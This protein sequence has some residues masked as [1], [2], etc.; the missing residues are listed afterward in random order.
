MKAPWRSRT[1]KRSLILLALLTLVLTYSGCRTDEVEVPP[2]TGPSGHRLFLT[3]EANPDHLVIHAPGRPRERSEIEI[4]L[5]NQ[6]G[7]GVAGEGIKLRITNVNGAELNIGSLSDYNVTTDSNGY[8][9]VIY[10]APDSREQ[11][12][13][14]RV[15]IFAILTNASYVFEVVG[16]HAL[17]L[18]TSSV[19]PGPG[20]CVVSGGS[21]VAEFEFSPDPGTVGQPVCFDAQATEDPQGDEIVDFDFDFDDGTTGQGPATCH[22]FD[23]PGLYNV[24][25]VATDEHHNCD[26]VSHLVEVTQGD[27][28]TCSILVSPSAPQIDERVQFTILIQDPDD[29]SNTVRR[30]QWNFGDGSSTTTSRTTVDH[31]YREAGSYTVVATITDDTGNVSTCSTGVTVSE[32]TAPTC[33][34]VF[35]PTAPEPG[36]T[37]LFNA[38]T[39]TDADGEVRRYIWNFGDSTQ[40]FTESDPFIEHDYA[41]EGEFT[42]TLTV[43]DDEGNESV[44]QQVVNVAEE[45]CPAITLTPAT[46]P[47]GQVGAA[48]NVDINAS[49]GEAPHTFTQ[50][51]GTLPPGLALSNATGEISGVP[52]DPGTFS[53]TIR[54]TDVNGCTGEQG[55]SIVIEP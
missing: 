40:S 7:Q 1:G 33:S 31:R 46:L 44:C 24:T 4:Q 41:V 29:P 53:F 10:T 6:L 43:E 13:T 21:P 37:V 52:T 34:F 28:A 12:R 55:Y 19:D 39:S 11:S 50:I 15:Y 14:I 25:L 23:A 16:R 51:S 32:G 45:E 3:V 48:Y 54:A 27:P 49:G 42:V 18:E 2:L 22:T 30:I 36:E 5:K 9:R 20:D 35:S 26:S 38:S 47:D 8:A 17:D